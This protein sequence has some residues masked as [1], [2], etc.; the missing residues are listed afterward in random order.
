MPAYEYLRIVE[1][2]PRVDLYARDGV[3]KE[4]PKARD[5]DALTEILNGLG[6]KRWEVIG[7]TSDNARTTIIMKRERNPL[8]SD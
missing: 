2:V 4:Y 8:A 3:H 7:V 6:D 1:S 5:K